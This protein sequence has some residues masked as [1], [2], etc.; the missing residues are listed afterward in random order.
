MTG[1]GSIGAAV[2][3][4]SGRWH[5]VPSP[6]HP[7]EPSA[8]DSSPD[9]LGRAIRDALAVHYFPGMWSWDRAIVD[10]LVLAAYDRA[11]GPHRR[12]VPARRVPRWA[13]G[14][15]RFTPLRVEVDID[16][17]VPDPV[18][19]HTHLATPDGAPVRYRDRIQLVMVDDDDEIW[20]GEHRIVREF[21]T[22]TSSRSTSA[23]CCS[24]GRGTR[25]SSR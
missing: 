13:A 22:T 14:V 20:V 19:P 12:P 5:A 25:S 17:H 15:D 2:P 6:P 7:P 3:G 8:A 16:V 1:S 9:T 24:A 21:A 11:G 4:T 23:R 10:P 18:L